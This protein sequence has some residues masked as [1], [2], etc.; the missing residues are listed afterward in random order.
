MQLIQSE[1]TQIISLC[2]VRLLG[3]SARLTEI[4]KT[5][6]QQNSSVTTLVLTN[7]C[8]CCGAWSILISE[9]HV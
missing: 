9:I 2:H 5:S 6:F 4:T 1:M 7:M 3:Y 8:L